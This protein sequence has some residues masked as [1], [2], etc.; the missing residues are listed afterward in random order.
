[1]ESSNSHNTGGSHSSVSSSSGT[2]GSPEPQ[3]NVEAKE[4]SQ[5]F[6]MSGKTVKFDFLRNSTCIAYVSLDSKKTAGKTTT[7]VES[8]KGKSTLVT[9]LPSDE[10][11]KYLN[12][13]VGN[14]GFA[15]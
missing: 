1:M 9:G 7:I 4:L 10:V 6:I 3:S 2:G 14:S 8:L 15:T 13:W 11:Y 12:I 5:A